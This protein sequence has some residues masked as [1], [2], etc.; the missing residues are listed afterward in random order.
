MKE[1]EYHQYYHHHNNHAY[2]FHVLHEAAAHSIEVIDMQRAHC[3]QKLVSQEVFG[4]H[5]ED[6]QPCV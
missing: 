5:A 1:N 6:Q 2:G 3:R 4:H